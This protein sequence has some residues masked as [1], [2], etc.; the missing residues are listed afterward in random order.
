MKHIIV[1]LFAL[2]ATG[3]SIAQSGSAKQ[4]KW[5]F[6][7][8][9]LSENL[10]EVRMIANIGGDYHMYAQQAGAD[11]PV[12]TAFKFSPN[13]LVSLDGK[14]KEEG[15]MVKKFEA[16]WDGNVNYYEKKVE[17]VQLVKL[18]GKVKTNVAGKVE[19]IVCNE[20]QCLPPAEV[21]FKVS[22]GG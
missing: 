11:G 16:A 7:S 12:P 19:F 5:T 14:T 3:V 10:Y 13:P 9:K 21:D 18:K 22:V 6:S 4:V 20:S 1:C 8:K 17:F 2:F 15:K